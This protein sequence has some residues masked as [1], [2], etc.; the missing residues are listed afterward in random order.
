MVRRISPKED[1]TLE[2]QLKKFTIRSFRGFNVVLI[3]GLGRRLGIFDYLANQIEKI[4]KVDGS[5][6]VSFNF[7]DIIHDLNLDSSYFEGWLHMAMESEIIELDESVY[8]CFKTAPFIFE[9]MIDR[10]NGF[11]V[12]N[13]ISWMYYNALFHDEIYKRFHT[14]NTLTMADLPPEWT[15]DFQ[16]MA[17]QQGTSLE[18]IFATNF[19][20]YKKKLQKGGKILEVGCGFGYHIKGWANL[21]KSADIV[22]IDVDET[23]VQYARKLVERN[24]LG[25]RVKI[26]ETTIEAF[27]KK[28]PD[29]Y[30]IILLNQV[31]HE[32]QGDDSIRKDILN[33]LYLMLKEDGKLLIGES[34]IPS[35][36]TPK[37]KFLFYEI[38]HKW[39]EILFGSRFYDEELF[40]KLIST[41]LF[42]KVDLFK[43]GTDYL[44]V[45]QK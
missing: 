36:F 38:V 39:F 22:G 34:M 19:K 11:Y 9:L 37:K 30:H 15:N 41:T 10:N 6:I 31:L 3:F 18:R 21:Y 12:G 32:I 20:E 26:I 27:T 33:D 43:R 13:L 7:D 4:R 28:H 45:V 40:R 16:K 17:G 8:R 24:K 1:L 14:G 23:A 25:N 35:I 2:N 5:M 44:W 29:E 42:T